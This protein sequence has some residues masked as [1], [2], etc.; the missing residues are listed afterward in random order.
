MSLS[1]FLKALASEHLPTGTAEAAKAIYIRNLTDSNKSDVVSQFTNT[2]GI[3]DEFL[4][5]M[6][7]GLNAE[8]TYRHEISSILTPQQHARFL[9]VLGKGMS[10]FS[11][12][13]LVGLHQ[14]RKMVN[15][16]A[17]SHERGLT[18]NQEEAAY[19]ALQSDIH[20]SQSKYI[21]QLVTEAVD[22]PECVIRNVYLFRQLFNVSYLGKV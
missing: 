6:A 22:R 7:A 15:R 13:D 5:D 4:Q 18:L 9:D 3:S 10:V 21:F 8:H 12:C 14:M 16:L 2:Q 17:V 19:L 1:V 11:A 20:W